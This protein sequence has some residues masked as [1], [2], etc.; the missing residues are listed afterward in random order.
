[1]PLAGRAVQL[2]AIT[3]FCRVLGMM[4][5]NGVPMLQALTVSKDATGST[6]L[7]DSIEKAAE[8]VRAGQTLAAPLGESGLFPLEILEMI[9][10]AEESNQLEKALVQIADTVERRTGRQVDMAVRLLEPLMLVILA[11]GIAFFALA[12]IL[13]IFTLAGSLG[14]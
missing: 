8:N 1:L 5:K 4:L 2:V 6:V 14:H 11:A 9:S 7:A 12:L 3:R 13:P 10:V